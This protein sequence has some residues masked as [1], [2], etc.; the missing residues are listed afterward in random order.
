MLF[1]FW[2]PESVPLK[3]KVIYATSKDTIKKL[4]GDQAW[5]TSKLQGGGQGSPPSPRE[6]AGQYH[7]P[8]RASPYGSLSSP[9]AWSIW[10][11]RPAHGGC[12][13]TLLP[14]RGGGGR[15][16][17]G[18]LL[19]ESK[20]SPGLSSFLN[21][22]QFWPSQ[23]ALISWFILGGRRSSSPQGPQFSRGWGEEL[24]FIEYKIILTL[25]NEL[26][27]IYWAKVEWDLH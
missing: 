13:L 18:C 19:G 16:L 17:R 2:V 14:C 23:T 10:Q 1:I 21:P 26:N 12:R 5:I 15:L 6:T 7:L 27:I 4:S 25:L 8:W 22:W 11:P 3:S 24:Y 20:P 9:P